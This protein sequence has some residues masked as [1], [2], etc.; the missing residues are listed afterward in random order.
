MP[1]YG[2]ASLGLSLGL[3][4]GLFFNG[5]KASPDAAEASAPAANRAASEGPARDSS[6]SPTSDASGVL[7]K[8]EVSAILGQP[9]T[10]V[11]GKKKHLKYK[12]DS[13]YVETTIE[14]EQ[15]NAVGAMAGAR[16]ATTSLG[17]S[18][19][20]VPGLGDEAFFGAM[21]TLYVRKGD[22]IALIQA[23]NYAQQA[24]AQAM[25]R[26]QN[27]S[28]EDKPKAMEELQAI[29]KGAPVMAGLQGADDTKGAMAVVNAA[30][31]KQGTPAE[32]KTRAVA[33]ALAKKLMEKL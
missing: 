23:P 15:H 8:E 2:R 32:A 26:F 9:V 31:K 4:T 1:K 24:Q 14:V 16:K 28:A 27:A 11:E 17:G 6:A 33:L 18:P 29:M 25:E 30:S 7:T 5:C 21:S 22:S 19:E 10:A 3:C 13:I 12:T 20:A